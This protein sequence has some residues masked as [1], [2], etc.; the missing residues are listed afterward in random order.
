MTK[1]L[2][3][4]QPHLDLPVQPQRL[5]YHLSR[6]QLLLKYLAGAI[7]EE[8]LTAWENSAEFE[9][10]SDL[11]KIDSDN[12]QTSLLRVYQ[13]QEFG[14]LVG[15][16]FIE[17]KSELDR[18][19]FST[20]Q[21]K[22]LNLAEDLYCQIV[23]RNKSFIQLATLHSDSPTAKRGGT[24]GPILTSQLHPQ[25]QHYLI[26]LEPKQL[27]SIFKLDGYY[28]FLR[29]DRLL[30]A[31]LTHQIEQQLL[32]EL[33]ELRIKQQI[34]DRIGEIQVQI[35]TPPN[36]QAHPRVVEFPQRSPS[37]QEIATP[38][39]S[40]LLRLPTVLDLDLPDEITEISEIFAPTSSIFF[41]AWANI[42][43]EVNS[44][45][46]IDS[47][48]FFPANP[49]LSKITIAKKSHSRQHIPALIM[50]IGAFLG[51]FLSIEIPTISCSSQLSFLTGGRSQTLCSQF[52]R[53]ASALRNRASA[54]PKGGRG[55]SAL[56]NR[57]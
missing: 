16:R 15:S 12:R 25:I 17:R 22:D 21:V 5:L 47:S 57:K 20:I 40:N 1:S 39:R 31:Q 2:Q 6:S 56:R 28:I 44:S 51:I 7:I 45:A 48:F 49:P 35:Y 18:V 34:S 13:Q 54:P 19:L 36:A 26:G 23:D 10:V 38:S 53:S 14:H 46:P 4:H 50:A 27:S 32:N 9:L 3:S 30:P 29:L 52:V 41:P 43:P 37:Q 24:I 33:F 8:T 42:T 11:V 55:A